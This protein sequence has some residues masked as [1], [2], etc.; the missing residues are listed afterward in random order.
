ME[1]LQ[2]DTPKLT[3]EQALDAM[4]VQDIERKEIINQLQK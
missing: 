3:L 4:G 2:E 1:Y